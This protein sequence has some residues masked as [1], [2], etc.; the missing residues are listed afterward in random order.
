MPPALHIPPA[1]LAE[2]LAH[3]RAEHPNEA[4]GFLAGTGGVCSRY[5]PL[6]NE[7]AS[8][9]AFRT[10]ARSLFAAFRL[11]RAEGLELLA[12]CHSHPTG[13][14]VPSRRDLQENTYGA[15]PWVIVGPDDAVRAWVL[16]ADAAAEVAVTGGRGA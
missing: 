10:A 11:M 7:L 14:P 12:V 16:R 1:V 8:P 5:L 2:L 3:C 6:V 13:E 4:C 9:T 15:V